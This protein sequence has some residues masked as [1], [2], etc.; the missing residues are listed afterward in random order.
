MKNEWPTKKLGEI[1]E[2][3]SGGTPHT[4]FA[5]Y[6][7]GNI[8]W[9]RSGELIDATIY[10][11]EKKISE[12]GLK[13]SSAKLF[14]KNSVL[15]ALT[16]ATVGK[17]GILKIDSSTNQ[18]VAAILP[19][20]KYF[21]PEFVWYFLRLNYQKIKAHAYGGAQPHID[22]GDI[23][24]MKIPLPP[25]KIQ[26][27]IVERLDK[28]AEA[29]KLNDDLIQKADELLQSLLHKEFNLKTREWKQV[30]LSQLTD[31]FQDG[32]W[33][34]SDDQS[35]RGIRLIQTG[36]IGMGEYIDKPDR[37][38]YI[39]EETFLKLKCTEVFQGDT[40]ISR[41]P[42]P[43]GRSCLTPDFGAKMITA[44]DC[45]IVRFDK[46]K[47]MPK[48]FVLYSEMGFYYAELRKHLTGSSRQ[49]VSRTNLGKTKIWVPPLKIQKQIVEKL[50][51]V[52]DYKKQLL[53]QRA[54]L[55]ELFGSVLHKSMKGGSI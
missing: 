37:A 33:I 52:Q 2:I 44:V 29:E 7:N 13:E 39:S 24:A 11:T 46:E 1:T 21:I 18:S 49:R 31:F 51:A 4:G 35:L 55:K 43:V 32:N 54:K 19:N 8:P 5:E 22:Q 3:S 6:W 16:G 15:I 42:D 27:Q 47:I 41:L 14:S 45:T 40:L 9:L 50:S 36:N 23:K 34:E 48:Y 38:R 10:D 30:E 12:R 25:I 53:A 28:I 26:K 20:E 17:T